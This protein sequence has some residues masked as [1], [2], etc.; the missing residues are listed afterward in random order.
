MK[1]IHYSDKY[2]TKVHSVPQDNNRGF[3]P[4]GLWFS[5]ET[6]DGW[7]QWCE[8]E[9]YAHAKL[10]HRTRIKIKGS[11]KLIHIGSAEA[12]DCFTEQYGLLGRPSNFYVDWAAVAEK[13]QG[14]II[15]PY[16][17]DRRLADHCFWYYAWDCASG[18]IW[19]AG[20]I[21]SLTSCVTA[22]V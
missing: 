14:I 22:D 18:C 1:F 9:N 13:Y 15:A 5:P 8:D 2:L 6:E 4:N 19:D 16:R 3:K 11:A 7:A 17:Y 12:L 20:A 21:H 10:S